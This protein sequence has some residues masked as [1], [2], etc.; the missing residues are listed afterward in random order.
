MSC[1][2]DTT[3]LIA[4]ACVVSLFAGHGVAGSAVP[5]TGTHGPSPVYNDLVLPADAAKE[6]RWAI[7]TPPAVGPLAVY[8]DCSYAYTPPGG[9][10]DLTVTYT[11]R[12]WQDGVDIGTAVETIVIG[13]GSDD[14][15]APTLGGPLNVGT[16]TT[17]SIQVSWAAGSDNVAVTSYEVSTDGTSWAD[18]GSVLT[19]T[20]TGLTPSASYTLRVRAKDAAGNVS[21]AITATQSTGTPGDTTPP[22]LTGAITVSSLTSTGY[23]L[24]WPAGAD[25]VAVT[26][27]ERSL[28]G[29]TNWVDVGNVLTVSVTGRT[30]ETTDAVRVRAKDSASNVSTPALATSVSLPA[31]SSFSE[32]VTVDEC[33]AAARLDPAD[34][35]LDGLL[36]LYIT[37][38]RQIAEQETGRAYVAQSKTWTGEDW[39][40]AT[41]RLP[42]HAPT[43]V[44]IQWWDGSAW[45]A[46]STGA[47][48]Y[49]AA[50]SGF[51]VAPI[52]GG[53]W[54]TL[55][56][57][58]VGPRVRI[59]AAAGSATPYVDTPR[60]VRTFIL[61]VV[62]FWV[63]NPEMAAAS[64][65]TQVPL[66]QRL[67]DP[68]RLWAV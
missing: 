29:G 52:V 25:N 68:E 50:G 11:Y 64:S 38:A 44:A 22:T 48:A 32:P 17:T 4:G 7:T 8:E 6:Y 12:L 47:Y 53:S 18:V 5:S 27:Y 42:V 10:V 16:V 34:T 54:P 57:V 55:G 24:S 58:A 19:Y 45:Q 15:T 65:L 56:A 39:P 23:V 3:P 31:A 14:T 49:A 36:Q 35:S 20:F 59:T 46:L 60:C 63:I 40:A 61:A 21:S 66:F 67:L 43:A 33:K 41:D 51:S 37:A 9:T 26:S 28:D 13:A 62:S 2:V 1:R 30:P